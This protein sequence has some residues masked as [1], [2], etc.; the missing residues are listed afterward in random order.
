M[1]EEK[2]FAIVTKDSVLLMAETSGHNNV[3]E[4]VAT[5]I[6]ED[7]TYR[8]REAVMVRTIFHCF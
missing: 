4:E 6:G 5:L 1:M 3:P 8:L 7:V 2:A